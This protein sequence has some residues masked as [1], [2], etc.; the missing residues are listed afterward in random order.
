MFSDYCFCVSLPLLAN[1]KRIV[2]VL[3]RALGSVEFT[4]MNDL[5]AAG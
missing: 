3:M 2:D 1:Q 4:M 5:E